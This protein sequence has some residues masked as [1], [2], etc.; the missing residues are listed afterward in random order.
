MGAKVTNGLIDGQ[1]IYMEASN[2]LCC[3]VNPHGRC[4]NCGAL[5]CWPCSKERQRNKNMCLIRG[6]NTGKTCDD[7]YVTI[8]ELELWQKGLSLLNENL[9]TK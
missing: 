6:I 2:R 3:L 1:I 4:E 8:A 9:E 7:H 5:Y